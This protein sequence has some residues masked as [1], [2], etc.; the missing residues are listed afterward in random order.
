LPASAASSS[1]SSAARLVLAREQLK[2]ARAARREVARGAARGR[3]LRR[4][5][6]RRRG[7]GGRGRA[8]AAAAA[9]GVVA[10]GERVGRRAHR[11]RQH[12]RELEQL[13]HG[14]AVGGVQ[15]LGLERHARLGSGHA[16]GGEQKGHAPRLRVNVVGQARRRVVPLAQPEEAVRDERKV[17]RAEGVHLRGR[18]GG[19]G[20]GKGGGAVG[21]ERPREEEVRSSSNSRRT[22]RRAAARGAPPAGHA[23]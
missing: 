4:L 10:R 12:A 2:Q 19:R 20:R 1:P 15:R 18:A 7:G 17:G 6:G 22:V 3:E 16:H 13:A 21:G 9:V 8:A 14:A 23:R 11:A 5:D